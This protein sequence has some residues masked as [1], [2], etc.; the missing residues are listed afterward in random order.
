MSDEPTNA[1]D[2]SRRTEEAR[3]ASAYARRKEFVPRYESNNAA[4]QFLIGQVARALFARLAA[5]RRDLSID[6]L[7]ELGC[8]DG[9]WLR[10]FC[11]WGAIPAHMVGIDLLPERVETARALCSP[12]V[13]LCCESAAELHFPDDSFDLVCQFTMFTSIRSAE[14]KQR[15]AQEMVRVLTPAGLIIWYDFFR[16]NPRN[17]DVKGIGRRELDALF[18]DCLISAQRVTLA[19]PLARVLAPFSLTACHLLQSIP[20]LRTHY[21]A[22]IRPNAPRRLAPVAER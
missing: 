15:V 9:H 7:L 1:T 10:Q 5:E 12:A 13:T 17:P 19:P 11:T 3:I 6:R 14:F 4:N 18:P 16:D 2:L 8:G 22:I 20:F 21:L